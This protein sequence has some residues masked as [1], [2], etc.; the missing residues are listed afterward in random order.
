M[1][2]GV[3]PLDLGHFGSDRVHVP[4]TEWRVDE[5]GELSDLPPCTVLTTPDVVKHYGQQDD[6]GER[7]VEYAPGD[8]RYF[9][10]RIVLRTVRYDNPLDDLLVDLLA[11][12]L[13]YRQVASESDG[14]QMAL[15]GAEVMEASTSRR[16]RRD[17]L[18]EASDLHQFCSSVAR[19]QL[20]FQD[21][22]TGRN[23][24]AFQNQAQL[25]KFV[26]AN[27]RLVNLAAR[28]AHDAKL[29]RL[30]EII[31]QARGDKV[32]VFCHYLETAKRLQDGLAK[33]L[34]HLRVETTAEAK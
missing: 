28:P 20:L 14:R 13:L 22:E 31:E 8:K 1:S 34:R 15:F 19:V 25:R 4:A 7:F 30:V 17:P 9:P 18:F 33:R 27:R 10:R 24:S 29:S 3:Q 21:L 32:T 6:L 16:G 5:L 12:D 2:S 26:R 11:G 23:H